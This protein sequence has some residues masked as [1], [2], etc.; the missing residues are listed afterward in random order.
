MCVPGIKLSLSTYWPAS[1]FSDLSH[2]PSLIEFHAPDCFSTSTL[3]VIL[4][5]G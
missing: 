5:T 3:G 2:Q 1:L 4:D